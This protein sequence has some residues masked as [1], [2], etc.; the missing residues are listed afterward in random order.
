LLLGQQKGKR[1]ELRNIN[2][3]IDENRFKESS[4][5]PSDVRDFFGGCLQPSSVNVVSYNYLDE[6]KEKIKSQSG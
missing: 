4:K 5:V 1:F 2:D 3:D 6:E